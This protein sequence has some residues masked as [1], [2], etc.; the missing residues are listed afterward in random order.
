MKFRT[1]LTALA[2]C[3]CLL[4]SALPG[5]RA[6]TIYGYSEG[7]AQAEE[8]GRWGFANAA[9]QVV[10]PLQYDSVVS[11]SL[12]MAAVNLHGKLGVIRP[13]GT[14]LIP[15]EYDTLMPAGY[16][17]YTAQKGG[18]WGVVSVLSYRDAAGN[19]TNQVWPL[20]YKKAEL[21]SSGG[22]DALILTA[23]DGKRTVVPLYQIP[24]RLEE[25]GVE[26]SQFPLTKGKLPVFSDVKGKD[27]YALWVDLA[28]NTGIMSGTGGGRFEPDRA[29]TVAEAIQMAA[30]MESRYRGDDFH[31]TTYDSKLWYTAAVTY[32]LAGGIISR[33]QFDSYDR[34]ITRRE[35]AQVFAAT[36][37]ARSLPERNSLARVRASVKDV[38]PSD[39][40]ADAIC[41][42]YSKGIFTGVDGS[43]RFDPDGT[44]TRGAA[45]ALAARL[46]R[47]EQRITLF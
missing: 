42:L 47:P 4:V 5:A 40:G 9:G 35:L 43:L 23:R 20:T 25:L 46:A 41:G 26:G 31:T 10:I 30:N 24:T 32:C 29:V 34:P 45:A 3:L 22:L 33:G 15:P 6:L 36:S 14:Y 13:D 18:S 7:L 11:F 1:R 17:L 39:P 37:L 21:G 19:L 16:G 27:W 2:V 38:A 12:G 8:N 44:T 28:Y